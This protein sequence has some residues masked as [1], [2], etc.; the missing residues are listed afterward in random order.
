MPKL[1]KHIEILILKNEKNANDAR[2]KKALG[3]IGDL[4]MLP[5]LLTEISRRVPARHMISQKKLHDR[6]FRP[7]ISHTKSA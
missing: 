6:I 1:R 2:S 7:K 4:F 5:I 3:K